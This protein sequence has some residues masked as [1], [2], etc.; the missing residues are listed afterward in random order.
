MDAM[1]YLGVHDA[2]ALVIGAAD[3]VL[4]SAVDDHL[5]HPV[6]VRSEGHQAYAFQWVPQTDRS[7]T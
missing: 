6:L 1:V 7:I 2:D 4:A 3:D 5:T